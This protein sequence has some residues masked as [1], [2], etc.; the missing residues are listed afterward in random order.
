MNNLF[1]SPVR[2]Q[3]R[4]PERPKQRAMEEGLLVRKDR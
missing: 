1:L 4:E 2:Y 3:D